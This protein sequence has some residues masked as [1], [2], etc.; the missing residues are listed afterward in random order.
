MGLYEL[1]ILC[2]GLMNAADTSQIDVLKDVTKFS[3]GIP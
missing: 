1:T 3:A 2:S